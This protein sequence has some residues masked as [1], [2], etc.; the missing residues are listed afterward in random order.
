ML[1]ASLLACV[2]VMQAQ[3]EVGKEYRIKEANRKL[4]LTIQGYNG[5]GSEGSHGSVPLLEKALINADQ[6]WTLEATDIENVYN[7]KSKSGYYIVQ[8]GWNVDAY[9]NNANQ[10]EV[11][12]VS[13]GDTYK[14]KNMNN[15]NQWWKSQNVG[16]TWYP[17]CDAGE[18]AAASWVLE[19]VPA[20]E[21]KADVTLTITYK[22]NGNNVSE[23]AVEK[24]PGA[25]YTIPAFDYTKI[26][27]CKIGEEEQ[28]VTDGACIITV[29]EAAATVTV[30]LATNFPFE[31]STDYETATWY[32]L[33]I[34]SNNKKYVVRSESAPYANT[35]TT[36]TTED[37]LWAFVGNPFDG[38]QVLN[39]AAGTGKTLGLDGN[40][41]VMLEGATTWNITK[42][43]GGFLLRVGNEGNKYFHDYGSKLQIWDDGSAAGDPGSAFVVT[44][45]AE[46]ISLAT[47]AMGLASKLD[48]YAE[49]SY[50]TYPNAA[51][52]E[53]KATLQGVATPT[54]FL[55]ALNAKATVESVQAALNT[56]GKSGAP[57]AGDFI[58]LKNKARQKFMT[59][60]GEQAKV[61]TNTKGLNALWEVVAGENGVKLKNCET[62]RFLGN[63]TQSTP[64][65]TI[66]AGEE[67]AAEF[68]W[69]NKSEVYAV[70]KP[71]GGGND[72][73]GHE[74]WE[75]VVGW[76]T[77]A[78]ATL[79]V[80][81]NVRPLSVVFKFNGETL[82]SKTIN[83]YAEQGEK[84]TVVSPYDFTVVGSCTVNGEALEAV[85][86]VY[87]FV[88]DGAAEVVVEIE[89]N[90]PFKTA[91]I[92]D[93]QFA[94]NT[95]WYVIKHREG[96]NIWLYDAADATANVSVK[97]QAFDIYNADHLWC[98]TGNVV[99]GFKIHNKA[100]AASFSL[101]N[102][103][104][105]VLVDGNETTWDIEVATEAF[106]A[107]DNRLA[108]K[109][110]EKVNSY[111]V[112]YANLQGG[113]LKGWWDR[114]LGS[115]SC[116]IS[117]SAEIEKAVAAWSEWFNVEGIVGSIKD[118]DE[119]Q[120]L[121][122]AYLA[123][124]SQAT[125]DAVEEYIANAEKVAL[126]AGYYFIKA[127]GVGNNASWYASY[128]NNNSDFM[129]V[130]TETPGAK[131]MWSFEAVEGEDGY[132]LQACNLGKYA[133]LA[134]ASTNGGKA[135]SI[136]A[137]YE[138][139]YKFV[140]EDKGVAK[141]TVKDGN[142]NVMRTE[143][144]G[145]INYW[146][147][148]TNETWYLIPVTELEIS[149]NDFA[150]ICLPFDVE[151]EGAQAYA[152]TST[153][154]TAAILTEKADIPAGQGA[155]LAG[156]GVATLKFTTAESDWTANMLKGS[157]VNTYVA[158]SAYVLATN[159]GETVGLYKAKL[160]RTEAGEK[161][162]EG[163]TH[164]LN[165]ANKAYLPAP[166]AEGAA[167]AMFVLSR[168]G[169][170]EDATGIDQLINN[171]EVV[172]Y[173]LAGRRVEKME[174]GVYIV[175]G[176]K[177]VK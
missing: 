121:I 137:D 29:P 99:D 151:V 175:N 106:G 30:E 33:Q 119:L 173:D 93:G 1:F 35:T 118:T 161:V 131:H 14:I 95:E 39:K 2:G 61:V 122:E 128:G 133:Q 51:V 38:I 155:I 126:T 73:Y 70:F 172:I 163:G 50:Y 162:E 127:T 68:V 26:V 129:A 16:G 72:Q 152:V 170:D 157:F 65:M 113:K 23:S 147:G 55:T 75:N 31:V 57:A 24:T 144:S 165:N 60:N 74:S 154:A 7:L 146:A 105:A 174:K 114:D 79:W 145:A 49:A 6:V 88:V 46:M 64:T 82:E 136:A 20:D 102:A 85:E 86:G 153:T 32:V 5:Q 44:S 53:A 45:E 67:G 25:E 58:M 171:G 134:N 156:D 164:F 96:N 54:D 37:A 120:T 98:F 40:N 167:P 80:A 47:T 13:N 77:D 19:E 59:D 135:S 101:S 84:Y 27:S 11:Q 28:T 177:V 140:F 176:K 92:T 22:F 100:V 143:G 91:T 112:N 69:E 141:F 41:G 138:N 76:Y 56:A 166:V 10:A 124:P 123:A 115:V 148:E 110:R 18:S 63:I 36:P 78:E 117:V 116:L 125:E 87:S 97:S 66:A 168:G 158:G 48:T 90:L 12:F 94:A 15:G 4:Y 21:F 109:Y 130:A 107:N 159:G 3:P 71:V 160:N 142:G 89:E 81:S 169:E 9:N 139:G 62:G 52:A 149:I 108:F 104:P 111:E 43:N 34:R 132:K 103:E 150:S 42:G 83:G 17:F 8:G